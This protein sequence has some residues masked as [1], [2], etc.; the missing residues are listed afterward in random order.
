MEILVKIREIQKKLRKTR[1]SRARERWLTRGALYSAPRG[2]IHLRYLE[3]PER[4]RRGTPPPVLVGCLQPAQNHLCA[5]CSQ[6][7]CER[8]RGSSRLSTDCVNTSKS[9]IAKLD[10][11]DLGQACLVFRSTGAL[12]SCKLLQFLRSHRT[13]SEHLIF[14]TSKMNTVA[15]SLGQPIGSTN[16][17]VIPKN[18]LNN[19][20]QSASEAF[21]AEKSLGEAVEKYE[22]QGEKIRRRNGKFMGNKEKDGDRSLT[23]VQSRRDTLTDINLGMSLL[24]ST[25]KVVSAVLTILGAD[26]TTR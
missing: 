4:G 14:V 9:L 11:L 20:I 2:A 19:E 16:I 7:L 17:G 23:E 18:F 12:T 21:V 24:A 8:G 10:F 5:C 3:A 6:V 22:K 13:D 1:N 15:V 25:I 26:D